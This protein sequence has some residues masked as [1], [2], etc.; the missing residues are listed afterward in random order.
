MNKQIFFFVV[1]IFS[2]GFAFFYV[3]PEYALMQE[4]RADFANL[5]ETLN[6]SATVKTLIRETG[7]NLDSVAP[8]DLSRFDVFL[9]EV[10]DPIHF[11]NDLQSLGSMNGIFLENI[12]V[13]EPMKANN[14]GS[15]ESSQAVVTQL[16]Q[17]VVSLGSNSDQAHVIV[18]DGTKSTTTKDTTLEKKYVVT[19]ASFTFTSTYE[20]FGLFID[21]LEKSLGLI[22]VT[23]LSFH[24]YVES[25][26]RK[27]KTGGEQTY[28]FSVTIETYSL[29]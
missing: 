4:R 28:E 26:S 2:L 1:I 11:A 8:S 13:A 14:K 22:N 29:K 16:A 23:A 12:K 5:V 19:N 20:K 25:D 3:K 17:G 27:I 21:D 10:I 7:R 6:I 24:P 15:G 9:P 18:S